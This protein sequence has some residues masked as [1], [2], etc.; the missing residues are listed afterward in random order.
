MVPLLVVMKEC[1]MSVVKVIVE[2]NRVYVFLK[3]GG[4]SNN[5]LSVNSEFDR[6][7]LVWEYLVEVIFEGCVWF[8]SFGEGVVTSDCVGDL[9]T[10]I[11]EVVGMTFFLFFGM[12][13]DPFYCGI[14]FG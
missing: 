12:G 13:W 6:A 7:M 9:I 11:V 3:C 2:F 14:A 10:D 4:K 5:F 8:K 1:S